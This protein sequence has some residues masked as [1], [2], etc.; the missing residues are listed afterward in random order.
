VLIKYI[1]R[2]VVIDAVEVGVIAVS[3]NF[4]QCLGQRHSACPTQGVF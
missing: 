1:W 2:A 3:W 4:H